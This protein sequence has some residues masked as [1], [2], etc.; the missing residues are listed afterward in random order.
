MN[1][2]GL[3]VL[4]Q[5]RSYDEKRSGYRWEDLNN[6]ERYVRK[7]LCASA[8]AICA[9]WPWR[10]DLENAKIGEIY[11]LCY[12]EGAYEVGSMNMIRQW[13][14]IVNCYMPQPIAFAEINPPELV[15]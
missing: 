8:L 12:G 7:E 13:R 10:Y 3:A 2:L 11:W 5:N 1:G 4:A 9:A 6:E 14:N 15:P